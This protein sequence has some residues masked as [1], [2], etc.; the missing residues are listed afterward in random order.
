MDTQAL[1]DKACP[2]IGLIGSAFYFIPETAE[3]GKELG[4]GG[5]E[6]YVCGRGGQL[7]DCEGETVAA[8]FGYFSPALIKSVWDAG[9][10]KV[11]ARTCGTAH[12]RAAAE[13][14]R[15]KFG[16]IPGL[17]AFV[18]ALDKVNAAA[19]PSGLALYAAISTEPLPADAAGRAMQLIA[20]LR[21]FR[22]SAHLVALR[23][24]GLT[25]TVAHAA[26][27]D[28]MWERFGHKPED[29]PVI[30]DAVRAK[31]DEAERITDAI[32]A[33]AYAVLNDA[34]Q[35][36]LLAG[37]EAVGEALKG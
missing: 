27:R 33:P 1:M 14:G 35:A 26:K 8:A 7:G 2:A 9:T 30:D 20:V 4:L 17:D 15:R 29:K 18:A 34:E 24:V 5:M 6:F 13:L 3:M 21:E 32:C 19:D 37:L 16:S 25:D 28:D 22:G 10:A 12:M 23:A 11:P 36:A 31:L